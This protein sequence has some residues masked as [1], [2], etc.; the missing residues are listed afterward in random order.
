MKRSILLFAFFTAIAY[1]QAGNTA[2]PFLMIPT[3]TE[4]NGMGGISM[5]ANS[6][7]PSS[8]LFNP[9]QLGMHTQSTIF[10]SEINS[11]RTLWLQ[12]FHPKDLW[13]TNSSLI[14]GMNFSVSDHASVSAGIGYSRYYINLGEF[15]M[16]QGNGSSDVSSF[17][18]Y[19]SSDNYSLGIGFTDGLKIAFGVT[20]KR[21]NSHLSPAGTAQETASG[22]AGLWAMD[23]GIVGSLPLVPFMSEMELRSEE[24]LAPFVTVTGAYALNNLGERVF[25]I[26]AAQSDPLPRTARIGLSLNAGAAI[27]IEHTAFEMVNL[28]VAREAENLLLALSDKN[29]WDYSRSLIGNINFTQDIINGKAHGYVSVRS[30]Y[31]LSIFETMTLRNGSVD[32]DGALIYKT[33]GYSVSSRGISKFI[34]STVPKKEGFDPVN[35]FLSH[36]EIRYNHSNYSDHDLLQGTTFDTIVLSFH[37]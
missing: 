2:V 11:Q 36:I 19:E 17:H 20:M 6:S 26:D 31:S 15:I 16:A 10:S 4:A 8:I 12:S 28:T 1:S 33:S 13:I 9:A 7:S 21:I 22:K 23:L 24:P 25:Y 37:N 27:Q 3:S 34:S 30:G 18:G 35:F 14:C 29:T 32:G 5:V